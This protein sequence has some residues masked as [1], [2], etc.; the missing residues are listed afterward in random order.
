M[1]GR[2]IK[3]FLVTGSTTGLRSAEVLNWTG[4]AFACPRSQLKELMAGEEVAATGIYF[5]FGRDPNPPG[6][7]KV[8]IGESDAVASRL[9][10]HNRDVRWDFWNSEVN[11]FGGKVAVYKGGPGDAQRVCSASPKSAGTAAQLSL[12]GPISVSNNLLHLAIDGGVPDQ[13]GYFF[14]GPDLIWQPFGDGVLCAGGG[15]I[16]L[17]RIG[18]P[19]AGGAGFNLS[20]AMRVTFTP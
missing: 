17:K 5:L 19:A 14:Y 9:N 6:D 10:T 1:R 2:T 12:D 11:K 4:K 7:L 13:V 20:D 15:A 16:G 3:L 8:Y 18:G